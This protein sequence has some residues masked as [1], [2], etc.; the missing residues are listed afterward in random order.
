MILIKTKDDLYNFNY[1]LRIYP[2]TISNNETEIYLIRVMDNSNN[3]YWIYES[4]NKEIRDKVYNEIQKQIIDLNNENKN[5][6]IDVEAIVKVV[7]NN[8]NEITL[9]DCFLYNKNL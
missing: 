7:E 1:V 6:H 4:E 8:I 3:A 9:D 2:Y 5:G